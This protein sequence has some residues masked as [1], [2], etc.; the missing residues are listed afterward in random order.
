[1]KKMLALSCLLILTGC[2][3]ARIKRNLDAWMGHT[4]QE[5]ISTWGIPSGMQRLSDR[6]V[7]LEYRQAGSNVAYAQPLGYGY[8]AVNRQHGSRTIFTIDDGRIVYWRYIP[9]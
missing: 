7:I 9:E 2:A 1:M 8:V 4:D 6:R 5:L 3:G